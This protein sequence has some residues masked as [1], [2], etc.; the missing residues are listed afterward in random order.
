[1]RTPNA[2]RAR[3][4]KQV[5]YNAWI[6]VLGKDIFNTLQPVSAENTT[7]RSAALQGFKIN[8]LACL[9]SKG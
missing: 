4:S 2:E 9:W 5:G 7:L 6:T 8:I 3:C 1:M